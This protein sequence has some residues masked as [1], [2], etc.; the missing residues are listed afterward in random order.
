M[1]ENFYEKQME[2]VED[3]G[4]ISEIQND[5]IL[6]SIIHDYLE[7]NH[8]EWVEDSLVNFI[9]A[10]WDKQNVIKYI[11]YTINNNPNN[12]S[13]DDLLQLSNLKI[14]LIKGELNSI[15]NSI[16]K[17]RN[18]DFE[19]VWWT[20]TVKTI[21]I[22]W[23]WWLKFSKWKTENIPYDIV[24]EKIENL[25]NNKYRILLKR[26]NSSRT[27][28]FDIKYNWWNSITVY[29]KYWRYIWRQVIETKQKTI[30]KWNKYRKEIY[31]TPASFTINTKQERI[32]LNIMFN[33]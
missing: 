8:K 29:D 19:I 33:N 23:K 31:Q 28:S 7:K 22:K 11:T 4:D 6:L 30:I 10:K 12:L 18:I 9:N 20:I 16:E 1:S 24:N 21:K 25:W 15:N 26:E 14:A 2:F 13:N 27:Y 5:K 32:K 3:S 17:N